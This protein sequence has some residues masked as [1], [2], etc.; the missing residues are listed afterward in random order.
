MTTRPRPK[1][2]DAYPEVAA[3]LA[4]ELMRCSDHGLGDDPEEVAADIAKALDRSWRKDGYNIAKELEDS[5]YWDPDSDM[6][7]TLD[8]ASVEISRVISRMTQEWLQETGAQPPAKEGDLVTA[9]WG[10]DPIEGVVERVSM[11]GKMSIKVEG[12]KGHPIVDWDTV[13]VVTTQ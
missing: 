1:E 13:K 2:E 3:T 9:K 5:C 6:V 8:M 10:G 7:S 4:K 11:D 12:H